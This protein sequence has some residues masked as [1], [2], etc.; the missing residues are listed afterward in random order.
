[1]K[2]RLRSKHYAS[3]ETVKTAVMKKCKQ[4]F[5]WLVMHALIW[6]WNIAI[7]RNDDYVQKLGCDPQRTSFILVYDT[8][9]CVG[10]YSCTK[11]KSIIFYS[12]SCVCVYIYT[13]AHTNTHTHTH[14]HIYIYIY[15][16][17]KPWKFTHIYM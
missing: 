13:H 17:I 10:D 7:E 6:R 9:S 1:M 3:V 14:T 15:I 5:T 8:C 11:E 12:P 16:Y 2:G 4:N